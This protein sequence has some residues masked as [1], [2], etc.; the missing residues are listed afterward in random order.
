MLSEATGF[1]CLV[2]DLY[3]GKVGLDAEEA[4]HVSCVLW[5]ALAVRWALPGGCRRHPL[6]AAAS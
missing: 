4:H 3:K 5:P 1:R 2:P 6:A